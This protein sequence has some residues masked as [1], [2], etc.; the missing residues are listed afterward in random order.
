MASFPPPLKSEAPASPTARRERRNWRLRSAFALSSR[1]GPVRYWPIALLVLGGVL[2]SVAIWRGSQAMPAVH[3]P[4]PYSQVAAAISAGQIERLRVLDGGTR[5]VATFRRPQVVDGRQ[6]RV[7]ETVVPTRAVTLSDLERWSATGI[8]VRVTEPRIGR[9]AEMGVQLLGVM[10]IL[11]IVTFLLLRQRGGLG[12]KRFVPTPPSRQLTLSD[13]G[14]AR[15]AQAEL[16]DVIAYLKDPNRFRAM[17]ANCPRGVLLVGPPGTGKTLLARAV[18][19]EAGC[20]VIVAAGSDFNEMYVGVGSRRVRQLAKQAREASPCIIFIDEFDS[21]GGR[22]GR[23]NRSGEEE[24]TLNQLL[25]EMDGMAANEGI[26]WMAATNR[27]D[28][29]DPAVRRPGRFDRVVEVPLPGAADRLEILR[30][31]AARAPLAPD[32]NLERLSRLTVGHSGAELA[33]LLNEAA[34]VA[35]HDNSSVITNAHI[36]QARDKIMLGRIRSG[37]LVSQHERKLIALHEA[38]HAVVGLIACPEDKLHKVTIEP[39]GRSLG[40]AH[41]APEADRH[42][43]SRR[44]L[45]GI[46]AKALGGRAAELVF[47]GGDAVTSGAGGD[48]VQAT[49]VARRMVAEFGMSDDL[50]LISAEP[51][52]QGGAPSGQL[53]SQIDDAVRKLLAVQAQRAEAIVREHSAAVEAVAQALIQNDV[54][55]AEDVFAIARSHGIALPE[56][57]EA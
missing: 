14:G 11:A 15:E 40:A 55:T 45:E 57:V 35:V 4:V 56:T 25:V 5:V 48:L 31:H 33:N 8:E 51:V 18:A 24:V 16:R 46:L 20:P 37:I 19:G 28:M 9:G 54:L 43:Y 52:A 30:I 17:G 13:V 32:V 53:Q 34:I 1:R 36:E 23:P 47:L 39:R 29:L 2:A 38:G 49:S 26:I 50:G 22:R 10:A 42:L 7:V 44:Y 6:T 12:P 41:F 27:E 21:L 3:E